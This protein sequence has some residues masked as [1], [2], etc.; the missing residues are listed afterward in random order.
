MSI[1]VMVPVLRA[2][3]LTPNEKLVAIA[4]ADNAHDD[5]QWAWPAVATTAEKT[6]LSERTVQRTLKL[7]IE[8]RVIEVQKPSTA[9][10]PT[11]YRFLM[12]DDGK[13]LSF[14]RGDN[15]TP[16]EVTDA[17]SRGDSHDTEG[18]Q[19]DTLN[20]RE[21]SVKPSFLLDV[22]E[23]PSRIGLS[24][25]EIEQLAVSVYE[26]YPRRVGRIEAVKQ[27]SKRLIE[28]ETVERLVYA[29]TS[30]AIFRKGDDLKFTMHP[31]R[32]FGPSKPYLDYVR[33][34]DLDEGEAH[35][36][37][38]SSARRL[39]EEYLAQRERDHKESVPMPDSLKQLRKT[40]RG[41]L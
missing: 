26:K 39:S 23:R 38:P 9:S 41:N 40:M 15:L 4:L 32:F 12:T 21:P 14:G 20:V 35:A 30:Y 24:N 31:S 18:C 8:K 36:S 17:M 19:R 5:G 10:L 3:G 2:K 1:Y 16:L 7:L 11:V 25:K 13:D 37:G 6:A 33:G 29:L 27:I 22:V 28:G 34:G